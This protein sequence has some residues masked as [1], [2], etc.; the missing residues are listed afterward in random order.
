MEQRTRGQQLE[1]I[2][3]SIVD[4]NPAISC[5]PAMHKWNLKLRTQYH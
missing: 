5:I 4:N 1:N 3:K 2:K